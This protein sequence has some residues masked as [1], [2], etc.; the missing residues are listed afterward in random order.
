MLNPDRRLAVQTLTAAA[1]QP[2]GDVIEA[3]PDARRLQIN[4]GTT[5]RFDDLARLDLNAEGGR[6]LVSIFRAQ[7]RPLPLALRLVERHGLGS[8]AFMPL[9]RSPF[10]VIVAAAGPA[11][12][13]ADL[14]GFLAGPGQ[15]VNFARGTWHHPL[16]ALADSDFL[17]ID[18]G[19][20]N[21]LADCDELDIAA[22]GAWIDAE[23]R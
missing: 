6:P 3:T 17:V 7:A 22:W 10:L 12:Q 4:A 21:G 8:Q 20:A 1:F 5:E 14:R 23:S 2:Y 15:G 11:P 18:R 19:T 9:G 13:R 16:V